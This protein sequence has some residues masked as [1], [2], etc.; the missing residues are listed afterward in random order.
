MTHGL[1]NPSSGIMTPESVF[2]FEYI[3]NEKENE[4]L[5]VIRSFE[6]VVDLVRLLKLIS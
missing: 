6:I 2:L 3:A 5:G 1:P 4:R